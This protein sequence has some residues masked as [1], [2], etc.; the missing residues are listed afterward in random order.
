MRSRTD[1]EQVLQAA[2][3][4]PPDR[5]RSLLIKRLT[6]DEL[7]AADDIMGDLRSSY[8]HAEHPSGDG[9]QCQSCGEIDGNNKTIL[10]AFHPR[11]LLSVAD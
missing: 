10:W 8:G 11:K 9:Q 2:M 7:L 4:E 5:Q 3:V 6:T 1:I